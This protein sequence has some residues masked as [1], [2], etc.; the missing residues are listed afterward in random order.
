MAE[1]AAAARWLSIIRSRRQAPRRPLKSTARRGRGAAPCRAAGPYPGRPA[2]TP[3]PARR[4]TRQKHAH[5]RQQRLVRS[6][7]AG[8]CAAD[9]RPPAGSAR[10]RRTPRLHNRSPLA[11][12]NT[13]AHGPS[14]RAA[15]CGA[16]HRGSSMAASERSPF[17]IIT[18]AGG[19]PGV[20]HGGLGA[21]GWL[22]GP[23]ALRRARRRPVAA[24]PTRRHHPPVQ[25]AR[26]EPVPRRRHGG[27]LAPRAPRRRVQLP[28][29]TRVPP[30]RPAAPNTAPKAPG[31]GSAKARPTPHSAAAHAMSLAQRAARPV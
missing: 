31:Q 11:P 1:A 3:H 12:R 21:P 23:P 17:N 10:L 24:Q 27:D 16:A 7:C 22:A 8:G 29:P 4:A 19:A 25:G 20:V 5:A 18:S 28:H 6:A 14:N 15:A 13:L 2:T 30:V 9:A 26:P